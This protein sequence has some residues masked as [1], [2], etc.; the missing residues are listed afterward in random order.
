MGWSRPGAI[1]GICW[2]GGRGAEGAGRGPHLLG[3][4]EAG[5]PSAPRSAT[6]PDV[7]PVNIQMRKDKWAGIIPPLKRKSGFTAWDGTGTLD[8]EYQSL[9]EIPL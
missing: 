9:I 3:D 6:L 7:I 5:L 4:P 1:E 2:A 8:L